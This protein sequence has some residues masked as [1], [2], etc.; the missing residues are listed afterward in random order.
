MQRR[1]RN[2]FLKRRVFGGG[3]RDDNS[4]I[5]QSNNDSADEWDSRRKVNVVFKIIK[6]LPMN[7]KV[8]KYL[9]NVNGK[10]DKL[11]VETGD[12]RLLP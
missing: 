6:E 4:L 12:W 1:I 8:H 2:Y 3:P 10:Y 11:L 5:S 9:L 7:S